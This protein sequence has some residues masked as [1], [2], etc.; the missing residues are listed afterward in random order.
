M[1]TGSSVPFKILLV[2]EGSGGHLIPALQVAHALANSGAQVKVWYAHRPLTAPLSSALAQAIR[3]GSVEVDP[4]PVK[5]A[6]NPFGRLWQFGQLWHRAQR[7]F[8]AFAPDVVVGF[9]GWV[10]A[11]I[12]FAACVRRA[13][14][15]FPWPMRRLTP[16]RMGCLL[17]EQNVMMGRANRVLA[18]WVDRVAVS[19]RETPSRLGA[20]STIITGLPTRQQIGQSSRAEAAEQFELDPHRPTCFV[21][22]GSQGARAINR[23]MVRAVAHLSPEEQRAWQVIHLT[24]ATDEAMVRTAYAASAIRAW[25]APFLLEMEAAYAQADLVIARAGASTIAELAQCGKPAILIPYPYA[26]GH[27]RVNARLVETRGGGLLLEEAE[28]TA[29]RLLAAIRQILS[30]RRLRELMGAQMQGLHHVNATDQLARAILDLA[31]RASEA[32]S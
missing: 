1:T 20:A 2:A 29:E 16:R 27:Q 8:D 25:V 18:P 32:Q 19:F 4:I 31:G 13:T 10:S 9:G 21:L 5:T 17:H 26:G 7:C 22:G 12:V 6:S 30:D 23:L 15:N 14:A 11:P 28:A 3:G 24:G